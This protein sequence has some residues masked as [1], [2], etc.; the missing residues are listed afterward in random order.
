[1][2]RGNRPIVVALGNPYLLREIP[3][4]PAYLVGWGGFPV[5]QRAAAR[6]LLGTIPI[7]GHL[8]IGIPPVAPL[9]A[10]EER[11]VRAARGPGAP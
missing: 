9:G 6:A 10:G 7:T 1:V 11:P 3:D 4:V 2:E 8:P 5:S